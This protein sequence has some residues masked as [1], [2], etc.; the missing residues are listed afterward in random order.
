MR[1]RSTAFLTALGLTVG[2]TIAL[3]ATAAAQQVRVGPAPPDGTRLLDVEVLVTDLATNRTTT[4]E[5]GQHVPLT[6]GDRVRIEL[7][8]SALVDG[9][10]RRVA[11]PADFTVGGGGR[12]LGLAPTRQGGV[13]VHAEQI[14]GDDERPSQIRFELRGEYEPPR[15]AHG[16]VTFEIAPRAEPQVSA[17]ARQISERVARDL[18]HVLLVDSPRVE[19]A[20]IERI[21]QGGEAEARLL[22]RQ[23]AATAS[24][25]GRL[26]EVPPWEVTAHL[27]RHLLGRQGTAADLWR[28]DPG[29]RGNLE[30][31][32]ERG[33]SALVDAVL[34]SQEF[35]GRHPFDRLPLPGGRAVPRPR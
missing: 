15:L 10:G 5:L 22:A 9:T 2:L 13:V 18:A 28:T 35:R 24:Q 3:A 12:R 29:F 4:Y 14:A 26:R 20:W 21:E 23:L 25:S 11:L 31:L 27:Y 7:A 19:T 34:A 8:G 32:E 17:E 6:V 30:L 1:H 33:Y 16:F